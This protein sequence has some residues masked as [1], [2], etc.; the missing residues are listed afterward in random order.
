[1]GLALERSEMDDSKVAKS[2]F[3]GWLADTDA[4]SEFLNLNVGVRFWVCPEEA[5]R[6]R[7]GPDG[8][9]TPEV[10]WRDGIAHCLFPG[11]GNRSKEVAANA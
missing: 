4:M 10:E 9:P 2:L 1:M 5:H 11:C 7:R 3:D 8:W 6:N